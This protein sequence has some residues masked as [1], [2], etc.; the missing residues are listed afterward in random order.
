[1]G[2]QQTINSLLFLIFC[3]STFCIS[4]CGDSAQSD[5]DSQRPSISSE[6][7]DV[8]NNFLKTFQGTFIDVAQK[9]SIVID[10]K[11]LSW[12]MD[13]AVGGDNSSFSADL[14]CPWIESGTILQVIERKD[15]RVH[16]EAS[17]LLQF[18]I[19][20]A[21]LIYAIVPDADL[22]A[23]NRFVASRTA[24]LPQEVTLFVSTPSENEVAVN[25][26]SYLR[27]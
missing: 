8:T 23:C 13:R 27:K 6:G 14:K 10:G 3:S 15:P 11:D 20:K 4:G 7:V 17:H 12:R 5:F 22:D 25:G 9:E 24:A 26:S 16:P 21:Q 18:R 1:M 19:K 2:L